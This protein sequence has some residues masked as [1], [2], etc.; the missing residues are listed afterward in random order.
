[1]GS[2]PVFGRVR[3]ATRRRDRLDASGG[4]RFPKLPK[5]PG[6]YQIWIE[7]GNE[8]PAAYI[9]EAADLR[10]RMQHYRTPG[11][12]VPDRPLST[13]QRMNDEIK[14]AIRQSSKVTV[15]TIEEAT[16][17]IDGDDPMDRRNARLIV[18]QAAIHTIQIQNIGGD[19]AQMVPPHVLDR[20]GRGEDEYD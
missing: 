8:R 19:D 3:L 14:A 5:R 11:R 18:E 12:L 1:M 16:A 2:D 9:G 17:T 7:G 4:L 6:L 13:N 10:N 15:W 20:P